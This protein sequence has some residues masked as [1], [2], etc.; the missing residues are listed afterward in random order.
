MDTSN[1]L[2]TLDVFCLGYFQEIK[3]VIVIVMERDY[4]ITNSMQKQ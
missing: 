4:T 1:V 3:I 2:A